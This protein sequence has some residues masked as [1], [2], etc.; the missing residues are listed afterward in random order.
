MNILLVDDDPIA[1]AIHSMLLRSFGHEVL[2]A[3]DGELAW[4]LVEE[5][6]ISFVVSDWIMPNLAGV[7]LC[8]RIRAAEFD[9][10][11]YVILCTSKGAKS[12]LVEGM[13]AG[14]D[15]F[16]VKP[17]SAEELRVKVRAGERVLTLQQG[18]ATKNRELAAANARLQS[19]H[20]LIEDDLKAAA[21]IQEQL[22][23]SPALH[24]LGV[25]CEW[26][27]RPS[28]Y[29]AGDIFNFFALDEKQV[30]FYLLDVSGHGVPAAML[31]VTL[32]MVLTPDATHGSPLKSYDHST[33]ALKVSSPGDA[34]RELNRRFQS[35][36]DRY[37]TMLYGILD[38]ESGS[39]RLAQAG[40]PSPILLRQGIPPE[41]LGQGGMPVGLWPE[42]EFDCMELFVSP[43]D[44]LLL[45]SDGVTECMNPDGESFGEQRLLDYLESASERCLPEILRGLDSEMTQWGGATNYGDDV[46]LLA[47]EFS[48]VVN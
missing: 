26:R 11:I 1:R 15:D 7:D 34:I 35:R 9:R 17:I 38:T 5:K 43:G 14:A 6:N 12:D 42:I 40:H 4:R 47:I 21:W 29:I 41:M 39:L 46:S 33:G 45:Y 36:D 13:D 27:F 25:K 48:S 23:P 28:S 20:K 32:S 3:A 30:G 2:E 8:R 10:Y 37:F 16:V 24:A 44:R 19:A 18:L 22:L 31:S